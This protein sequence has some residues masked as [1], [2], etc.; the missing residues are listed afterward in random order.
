MY[1]LH[2]D[3]QSSAHIMSREQMMASNCGGGE[4]SASDVAKGC[5]SA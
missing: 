2:A 1:A 5:A 3:R 4:P